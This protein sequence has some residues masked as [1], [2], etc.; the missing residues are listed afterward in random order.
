MKYEDGM[1]D[2]IAGKPCDLE[3][4]YQYVSGYGDQYAIE[5]KLT[6]QAEISND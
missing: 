4:S 5:Q 2:C 1:L 6:N 3:Q